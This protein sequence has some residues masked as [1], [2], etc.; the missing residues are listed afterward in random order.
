MGW[1][2]ISE[3]L[4]E[5][6]PGA[7]WKL[8]GDSY[9][10]LTWLDGVQTKPTEVEVNATIVAQ[11][12][13]ATTDAQRLSGIAADPRTIATVSRLRTAT[14]AQIDDYLTNNVTNLAQ[15][16]TALGDIVKVLALYLQTR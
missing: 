1:R 13:A 16:R 5:L 6:R 14:A 4:A 15:A 7:Q 3:A 8:N 10:G 9:A 11:A 2:E 12:A